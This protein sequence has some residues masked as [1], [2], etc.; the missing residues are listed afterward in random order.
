MYTI[1]QVGNQIW[2]YMNHKPAWVNVFR[3][4][5]SD[6]IITGEWCDL[7]GGKLEGKNAGSLTLKVVNVDRLEKVTSNFPYGGSK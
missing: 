2:W 1:R 6:N 4:N 3:G 7:P 5:L